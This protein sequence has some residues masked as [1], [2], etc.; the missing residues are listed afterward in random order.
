MP[1]ARGHIETTPGLP[2]L[3]LAHASAGNICSPVAP[4][5]AIIETVVLVEV[6][7]FIIGTGVIP[8]ELLRLG[9]IQEYI[10]DRREFLCAVVGGGALPCDLVAELRRAID[11]IKQ[12]FQIV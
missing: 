12:D 5:V 3:A 2:G 4:P 7:I 1:P 8:D 11:R 10:V 6:G 9:V